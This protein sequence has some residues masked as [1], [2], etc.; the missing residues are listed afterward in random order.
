MLL[1]LE[2]SYWASDSAMPL[3][4]DYFS[5]GD[6]SAQMLKFRLMDE[7]DQVGGIGQDRIG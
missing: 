4:L 3:Y 6:S 5:R 7:K 1:L 2:R